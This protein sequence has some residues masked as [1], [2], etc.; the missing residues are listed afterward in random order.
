MI[1]VFQ[2]HGCDGFGA[3]LVPTM[4]PWGTTLPREYRLKSCFMSAVSRLL[5]DFFWGSA[6]T[7]G[8]LNFTHADGNRSDHLAP[9]PCT[10]KACLEMERSLR[11]S[12]EGKGR[13]TLDAEFT[14]GSVFCPSGTA[15]T[16]CWLSY[17]W[18]NVITI[19]LFSTGGFRKYGHRFYPDTWNRHLHWIGESP[20]E[21]VHLGW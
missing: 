21:H 2:L 1:L 13:D 3:R 18:V 4:M 9:I 8:T 11:L 20:V 10:T 19:L 17:P 7:D 12:N 5:L 15:E 6:L 14:R 16:V